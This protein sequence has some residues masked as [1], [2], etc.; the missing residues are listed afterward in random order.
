MTILDFSGN[1]VPN[2]DFV[3]EVTEPVLNENGEPILDELGNP[4]TQVIQ[5]PISETNLPY[6][7]QGAFDRFSEFRVGTTYNLSMRQLW[8][9]SV[10]SDDTNGYFDE[11]ES[12][13][14]LVQVQTE[15]YNK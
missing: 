8:N 10:I 5:V 9:M 6:L 4:E 13:K 7:T 11:K 1:P 14:T 3:A 12:Y 2:P 15:L